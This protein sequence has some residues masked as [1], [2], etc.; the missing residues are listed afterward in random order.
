ME[1]INNQKKKNNQVFNLV[2]ESDSKVDLVHDSYTKKARNLR[3]GHT[4]KWTD[5][6]GKKGESTLRM[7]SEFKD[8]KWVAF[9]TL[10]REKN[11][12]WKDYMDGVPKRGEP[13]YS[14]EKEWSAINAAYERAKKDKEVFDFGEDKDKAINFGLGSWKP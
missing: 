13:G 12:K 1:N 5:H 14:K 3:K 2:K 10:Y 8:G 6:E 11:G 4:L 9:P 7:A